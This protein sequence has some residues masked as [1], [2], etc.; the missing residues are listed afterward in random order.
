MSDQINL[1]EAPVETTVTDPATGESYTTSQG[2]M[3]Y[4]MTPKESCDVF[5]QLIDDYKLMI[6]QFRVGDAVVYD[7]VSFPYQIIVETITI[8][9]KVFKYLCSTGEFNEANFKTLMAGVA[10]YLCVK[11]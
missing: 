2:G 6:N 1:F 8:A 11:K 10:N 5:K 9:E 3:L 7:G 4:P